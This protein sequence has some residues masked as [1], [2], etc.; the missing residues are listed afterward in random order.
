MT[1][2]T[3]SQKKR[4]KLSID[5]RET[6]SQKTARKIMGKN[7]LGIPEVESYL[8]KLT[9]AQ[10]DALSVIPFDKRTL[11]ACAKMSVLVADVGHSLIYIRR[12]TRKSLFFQ[13]DWYES[14]KFALCNETVYWRLIRKTFVDCSLS[15]NRS[16]QRM[17]I[18][19]RIEE[20]PLARQLVYTMILYFLVTRRRLFRNVRVCTCDVDSNGYR[21]VVGGFNGLGL[22]I[23]RW[24]GNHRDNRLGL[25]SARKS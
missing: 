7:F 14:E 23:A 13:Q 18:D 6:P 19:K 12:T 15:K 8:G 4:I 17:L 10:L 5:R 21:V 20:I 3:S 22:D 24:N 2:T 25:S 11:R 16:E 9:K 1:R